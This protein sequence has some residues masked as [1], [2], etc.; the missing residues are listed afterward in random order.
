MLREWIVLFTIYSIMG[1]MFETV[2]CILK[3]GVWENRGFLFGP[4][5]P[6]YGCGAI[7]ITYIFNHFPY[8]SNG[9]IFLISLVGSIILEYSI[10]FLLEKFFHARWWDYENL[11]LNINGRISFFTSLAFGIAGIFVVR[12]LVPL[13]EEMI[14]YC[15]VWFLEISSYLF[16]IVFAMDFA[17]TISALTDFQK[18]MTETQSAFNTRMETLI[19]Y[20][21]HRITN[22]KLILQNQRGLFSVFTRNA[23]S[24]IKN[25]TYPNH[26][27]HKE[28]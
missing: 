23:I 20:P 2:Y 9:N 16:V 12:V 13:G 4:V 11:P 7:L 27:N 10:S 6:I 14:A 21:H 5:C 28:E 26:N 8:L 1:W 18:I 22:A 3:D 17:L 15:S 19:A 25:F 24:R